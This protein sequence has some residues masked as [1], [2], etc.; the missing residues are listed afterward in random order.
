[1]RYESVGIGLFAL[2][3][4]ALYQTNDQKCLSGI[5][6]SLRNRVRMQVAAKVTPRAHAQPASN[7]TTMS[8]PLE[9]MHPIRQTDT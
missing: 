2:I 5:F 1:M 8:S 4:S 6:P 9:I 3:I 7:K